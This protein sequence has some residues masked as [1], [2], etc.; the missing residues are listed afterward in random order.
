MWRW[1]DVMKMWWRY[2]EDVM[3][4]WWRCEDQK[5]W[6]RCED[7]KM[8]RWED[9]KMWWKCELMKMYSR[10]PL[11]EEPF[12]QTLS[13]KRYIQ[14]DIIICVLVQQNLTT[15]SSGRCQGTWRKCLCFCLRFSRRVPSQY[16]PAAAILTRALDMCIYHFVIHLMVASIMIIDWQMQCQLRNI[17]GRPSLS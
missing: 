3:K 11:L 2:D 14:Y 4:M 6:W 12:A 1:E 13:G 16:S 7:V 15:S 10:P 9:E 17:L 8:R 5:M